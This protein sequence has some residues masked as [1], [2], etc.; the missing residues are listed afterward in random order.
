MKNTI[1][2][3]V[4]ICMVIF[5]ST[6]HAID[7]PYKKIALKEVLSKQIVRNQKDRVYS[8]QIKSEKG[9]VEFSQKYSLALK[10]E[11]VNFKKQMLIFG[12]TDSIS[13]RAFQFPRQGQEGIGSYVLDCYDTGI[14]YELRRLE[15]GKKY[16]YLQVFLINRI[17]RIPHIKVKNLVMD[18]LSKVYE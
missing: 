10:L 16:S 3:F 15:K 8:G 14:E 5:I 17:K 6:V 12:I 4:I 13:T 11:D 7:N 1:F 9:L 18:R 2:Q